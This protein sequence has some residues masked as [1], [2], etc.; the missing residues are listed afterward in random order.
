M[1]TGVVLAGGRSWTGEV[2]VEATLAGVPLLQHAVD[3]L[4]QVVDDIVITI[5]P[6]QVLPPFHSRVPTFVCED[7]LPDRGPLSG[8]YTGLE[9]TRSGH[10]IVVPCDAPFME[11]ALLRLVS[12][13]V[14]G[15]DAAVPYA[16]GRLHVFPA[17]YAQSCAVRVLQALNSGDL[18]VTRLI[19]SLRAQVVDEEQL[20]EADPM[21]HS[22]INPGDMK[23]FRR[24]ERSLAIAGRT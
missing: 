14:R 18:S 22:F 11:P 19:S 1:L 12:A 8:I 5:D 13:Y 6:D 15:F 7:L 23:R 20:R 9:C 17:A 10:I 3:V 4:Q 2:R 16:E 24:A 21:M